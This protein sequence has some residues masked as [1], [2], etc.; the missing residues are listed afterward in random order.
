MQYVRGAVLTFTS[1]PDGENHPGVEYLEDAVVVID[2]AHIQSVVNYSNFLAEGGDGQAVHD[3]RPGLITPG[4]I[5]THI[6]Y[7]QMN[8]IGSYGAQLMEWLERYA[9]PGELAYADEAYAE[10]QAELFMQRLFQHG[11]TSAL[12]FTT[13]HPHVTDAL[14]RA[15]QKRS[16]RVIC[17]KVLMNRFA[18]EGLLDVGDGDDENRALLEKWHGVGRLSYAITPRFAIS[19]SPDQLQA[20][21][22]LLA[23]YPGVYLQ[24]HIAEHPDEIASTL[25]LF[26]EASDYAEVY[27]RFGLLT[28]HSVFAHGIHLSEDELARFRASGSRISFCP[29][30][31]LFLGSGLLDL[32]RLDEFDVAMGVGSDVGGGTHFSMLATVADGYKVNQLLGHNWHPLKAFYAITR[33]GAEA[34]H[35]ADRIGSIAPGFEADLVVLRPPSDTLLAQRLSADQSLTGQLFAY[36]FLGAEHAVAETWV[37]G[38]PQYVRVDNG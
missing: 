7:P 20:A 34:L 24:S 16:A 17:G 12:T 35:L 19:C 15:A 8:I 18:P 37:A 26:P 31:N 38:V 29:S 4:F 10:T 27:E 23:Q 11:T 2:G 6:H 1:D 9:F 3:V 33:G 5:D 28:D 21:G 30:S 32:Q 25:A 13:V 36:M 14:F 22:D